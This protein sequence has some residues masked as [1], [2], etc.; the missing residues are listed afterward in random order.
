MRKKVAWI[1]VI[2]LLLGILSFSFIPN[3]TS[4]A[5]K[6]PA[7]HQSH[8]RHKP[9]KHKKNPRLKPT[10]TTTLIPQPSAKHVLTILSVGDSLGED[11]GYGLQDIIG[12]DPYIHLVLDAVGSTGL[13]NVAYY[14]WP[15]IL[16]EELA[17]YHPQIMVIVIGG[18]DAVGFDQNGSPVEFG[19]ALW[20]RDYALRVAGMMSEA[21]KI[22]CQ[23][24]WV[25][26]PVM[27]ATSVL[28][29]TSMELLNSVY[30]AEAKVHPGV[31]YIPTW[32]L[33]MSR[34]KS[35]TQYLKNPSGDLLTVRDS[36]GVH[37]APPAG[38]ELIASDVLLEINKTDH[39]HICT[40][41][42]NYWPEFNVSGCPS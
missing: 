15:V 6:R 30:A 27:S 28:P 13:A 32:N 9:V 1:F 11:L 37:I 20:R 5:A 36:D 25:G 29:N 14:N 39:L 24:F 18:N 21:E 34:S 7:R 19:T 42:T 16:Q 41:S 23:V 12:S 3:T 2:A 35:F 17:K 33:F 22:K 40:S 8:K 10:A 26:L 31:I 38:Q 4:V